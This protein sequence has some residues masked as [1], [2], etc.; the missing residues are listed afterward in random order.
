MQHKRKRG[1]IILVLVIVASLVLTGC[2]A[3]AQGEDLTL[4][5]LLKYL[6]TGPG[7]GMALAVFLEKFPFAQR[8]FDKIKDYEWRRMTVLGLCV[9]FPG[10]ALAIGWQ[11]GYFDLSELTV[12]T[13]LKSAWEAYTTSSVVHGFIRKPTRKVLRR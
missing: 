11:M 13:I 4:E 1:L 7:I 3:L 12:F 6:I 5:H 9:I 2:Q 8:L 10:L